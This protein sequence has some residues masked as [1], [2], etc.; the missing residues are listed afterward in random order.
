MTVLLLKLLPLLLLLLL[1][2]SAAAASAAAVAAAAAAA[3]T[4]A[5]AAVTA[6][7]PTLLVLL[8]VFFSSSLAKMLCRTQRRVLDTNTN[9]II[10]WILCDTL[11]RWL[12]AVSLTLV[13]MVTRARK[14][15]GRQE[16]LPCCGEDVV[17]IEHWRLCG[18]H[19]QINRRVC[20]SSDDGCF[21][22]MTRRATMP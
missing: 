14:L 12:E 6:L 20:R 1:L 7:L 9:M 21:P 10:L 15:P 8:G 4:A 18:Q 13:E 22:E 2:A 5:P 16:V 17:G 11:A 3:A 19:T